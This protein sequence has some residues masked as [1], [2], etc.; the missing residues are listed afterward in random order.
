MGG[1]QGGEEGVGRLGAERL[2]TLCERS[3]DAAARIIERAHPAGALRP[4]FT[5]EDLLFI[6][7]TNA[8]LARA[9]KDAAPGAWRRGVGFM[10]DGLRAEA[11]HPLPSGPL[12]RNSC[13]R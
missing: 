11:A 8:L 5:G 6:F 10:L 3:H 12:T 4:D 2:M 9:S 7:G 1:A 13:T